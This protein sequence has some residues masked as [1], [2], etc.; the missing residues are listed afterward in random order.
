MSKVEMKRSAA[1]NFIEHVAQILGEAAEGKMPEARALR[2]IEN[3]LAA[4]DVK[5][6]RKCN[7]EA[8][9]NPHVD[10]CGVCMP[11]WGWISDSVKIK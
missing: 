7:G 2:E 1:A 4:I 9:G 6:S 3:H 5:P 10:H 11:R 8:H